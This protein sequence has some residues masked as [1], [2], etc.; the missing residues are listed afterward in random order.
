MRYVLLQ[1]ITRI[2]L[3]VGWDSFQKV[4]QIK[5]RHRLIGFNPRPCNYCYMFVPHMYLRVYF[6]RK[7]TM[8]PNSQGLKH[9][10]SHDTERE[11]GGTL[12]EL[13]QS[14]TSLTLHHCAS[15]VIL[16]KMLCPLCNHELHI[17]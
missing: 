6:N 8:R 1:I 16:C 13:P 9:K 14:R 17:V 5:V 7:A 2:I 12:G 10:S 15:T 3:S 4:L 11:F